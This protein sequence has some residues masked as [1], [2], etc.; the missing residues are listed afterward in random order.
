[1]EKNTTEEGLNRIKEQN[2]ICQRQNLI[3]LYVAQNGNVILTP[4]LFARLV[5]SN[6]VT[7][8]IL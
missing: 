1:M 4:I 5:V 2:D 8:K 3:V 6:I 7:M